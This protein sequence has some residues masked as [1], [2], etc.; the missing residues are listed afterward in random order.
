MDMEIRLN[1]VARKA[2][3]MMLFLTHDCWEP[4]PNAGRVN[5]QIGFAE[6]PFN[7]S[8]VSSRRVRTWL[9]RRDGRHHPAGLDSAVKIQDGVPFV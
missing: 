8:Y 2:F 1:S 5:V 3:L 6:P 4:S 9:A 7:G